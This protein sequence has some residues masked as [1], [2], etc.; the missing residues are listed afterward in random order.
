MSTSLLLAVLLHMRWLCQSASARGAASH[1]SL[2]HLLLRLRFGAHAGTQCTGQSPARLGA[3][4]P[5]NGP[6]MRRHGA[7][8]VSFGDSPQDVWAQLGA[9]SGAALR[10]GSPLAGQPGTTPDFF[11]SYTARWGAPGLLER[12]STLLQQRSRA[13]PT[14]AGHSSGLCIRA[15]QDRGCT[16]KLQYRQAHRR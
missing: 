7:A 4:H 6:P 10:G 9:P 5:R 8:A 1:R 14:A 11:Y 12:L 16:C 15:A 3:P 2:G 13:P